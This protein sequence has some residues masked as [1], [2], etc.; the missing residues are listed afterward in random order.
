MHGYAEPVCGI[1][2]IH[3]I[4]ACGYLTHAFGAEHGGQYSA[5][6]ADV[7]HGGQYS[8]EKADVEESVF[9]QR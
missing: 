1:F 3:E 9:I 7:E 2:P 6:K 5:E 8:A 4:N